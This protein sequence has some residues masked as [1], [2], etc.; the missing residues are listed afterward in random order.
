M[1]DTNTIRVCQTQTAALCLM[2]TRQ[3]GIKTQ[4]RWH[5]SL[6]VGWLIKLRDHAKVSNTSEELSAMF[7]IMV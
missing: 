4:V 2:T 7:I 5:Q 1:A 3:G 6:K